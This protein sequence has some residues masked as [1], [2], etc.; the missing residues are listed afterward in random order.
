MF[1]T[2][3]WDLKDI[4]K[5]MII[6]TVI[7][8][9]K[10]NEYYF[11]LEIANTEAS[12]S[13]ETKKN[14]AGKKYMYV[15]GHGKTIIEARN[16]LDY[17]LNRPVYLSAIKTFIFTENFAKEDLVEY[18]YRLRNN[19]NYRKKMII[20]TTKEDPEELLKILNERDLSVGIAA[21]ELLTT[22]KESGKSFLRPTLQL[23]EHFS[24]NHTCFL[25]SCIGVQDKNIALKGYSVLDGTKV[26]GYIPIEES[27][28]IIYLKG[29]KIKFQYIIPYKDI[30]YTVEATL[31]K[32]DIKPKYENGKISFDVKFDIEA[33]IKYGDKKIPYNLNYEDITK[34]SE[35]LKAT[36]KTEI[37]NAI[38]R[39]QNEFKC[40]YLEF[41]DEFRIHYPNDFKEMDWQKEYPDANIQTDINIDLKVSKKMD[42]GDYK[43]R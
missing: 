15:T 17:Q 26:D 22:L 36:M 24:S 28:G 33:T 2:G 6:I 21:D 16:N 1:L 14:G 38:D 35:I 40:D 20:L 29:E 3:C 25:I 32:R 8:D 42:Y 9:K 4:N 19:E 23:L 41:S 7:N 5:K 43:L 34:M 27:K 18:L 11:Y 10:D 30:N 13:D 31:K 39:S 12:S 37:A